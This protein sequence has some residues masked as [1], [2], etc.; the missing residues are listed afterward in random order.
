M[1]PIEYSEYLTH[2]TKNGDRWD[3]LAFDYY[4]TAFATEILLEA[5][6]ALTLT[7]GRALP[8]SPPGPPPLQGGVN[9]PFAASSQL[10]V[11]PAGLTL[12]VPILS[13]DDLKPE[14]EGPVPWR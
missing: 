13:P 8:D 5:N 9:P 11:L 12:V 14:E 6:P 4:G 7:G 2:N 1:K 3:L 10:A